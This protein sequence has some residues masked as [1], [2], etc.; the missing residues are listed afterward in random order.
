MTWVGLRRGLLWLV[1]FVVILEIVVRALLGLLTAWHDRDFWLVDYSSYD[2]R[3]LAIGDSITWG[4]EKSSYP[5]LLEQ[6]L[7][8]KFPQ[9]QIHVFNAARPGATSE[10][11]YR[12]L[13][14]A[15]R[16]AKPHIVLSMVG[17]NDQVDTKE[18]SD[19]SV[20]YYWRS[21]R[22]PQYL[23]AFSPS[24]RY[25]PLIQL[26]SADLAI[27]YQ[28]VHRRLPSAK[29]MTR[30]FYPQI[31]ATVKQA[32]TKLY[33]LQYP[34]LPLE[35]L[36]KILPKSDI[37]G[38]IHN[39]ANFKRAITE[40]GYSGVFRDNLTGVFGHLTKT[41]DRVLAEAVANF[42]SGQLNLFESADL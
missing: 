30:H 24:L 2:L 9:R 11:V 29:A 42:L 5:A 41:G 16:K 33:I 23:A 19:R 26:L 13:P 25:D 4:S 22:L 32:G 10:L 21:L 39:E 28:N 37:D 8:K 20:S 18:T 34:L 12:E 14:W 3:I 40:Y 31:A 15:L 27:N 17:V 7:R 6:M 1:V 36:Q 38:F 35:P